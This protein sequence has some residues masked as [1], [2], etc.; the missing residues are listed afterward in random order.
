[1]VTGL[2]VA[3]RTRTAITGISCH[4]WVTTQTACRKHLAGSVGATFENSPATLTI[5]A[6]HQSLMRVNSTNGLGGTCSVLPN[7]AT[8]RWTNSTS[9][10]LSF[11]VQP[12]NLTVNVS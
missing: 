10:D 11:D 2:T 8:A 7:D 1:V 12:A 4:M 5:D 9:G 6:N 3:G